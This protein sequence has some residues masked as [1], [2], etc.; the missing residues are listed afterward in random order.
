MNAATVNERKVNKSARKEKILNVLKNILIWT[1]IIIGGA[2]LLVALYQILKLFFVGAIL[3]IAW[4]GPVRP[5]R[6]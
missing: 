5:R 4:L 3:L 1:G 2:V 6:W